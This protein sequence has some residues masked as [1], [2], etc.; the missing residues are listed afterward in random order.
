MTDEEILAAAAQTY[1]GI[2]VVSDAFIQFDAD[3]SVC[4]CC[5][6]GAAALATQD[7]D[8]WRDIRHSYEHDDEEMAKTL[9]RSPAWVVGCAVGFDGDL[10]I[11][12]DLGVPLITAKESRRVL[13]SDVARAEWDAGYV[14]GQTARVQFLQPYLL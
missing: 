12:P 11:D 7:S 6:L 8:W 14:F 2:A 1:A 10:T 5:V 13:K 3:G 4:G 9:K